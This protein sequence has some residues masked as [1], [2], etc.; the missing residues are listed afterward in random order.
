MYRVV[1][2]SASCPEPYKY[3]EN[4]TGNWKVLLY[5]CSLNENKV[6]E[7]LMS[8]L[9]DS[10]WDVEKCRSNI[11]EYGT[12]LKCVFALQ[13]KGCVLLGLPAAHPHIS[14][15]LNRTGVTRLQNHC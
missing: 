14:L 1:Y 6:S 2:P 10:V 7:E 12:T 9:L 11:N 15:V 13:F 4:I 3:A 8:Q 5:F